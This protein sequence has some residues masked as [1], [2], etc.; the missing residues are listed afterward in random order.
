MSKRIRRP[1]INKTLVLMVD[2]MKIAVDAGH[3]YNTSGKRT[4]PVPTDIDFNKDGK[5]D[6]KKGDSIREHVAAVGV[7]YLLVQ[8]LKRCGFTT[9]MTGFNDDN[10]KDDP[11]T[12]LTERQV[13]I[14]N[15]KCDY[16]VSIHYNAYGDGTSFNSAE[17][18]EIYI[19][20]A[21]SGKSES[22]AKSVLK[23]L[24]QGTKQ[25]NRGI[26]KQALAMC[27][28]KNLGT[29]ASILCELCFMTNEREALQMMGSSA[30][31]KEAAQEICKGICEYTKVKYVSEIY[32]PTKTIKRTS[33]ATDIKWLQEKLNAVLAGESFI[34]LTVDGNYG[35][36]T[37]IAVLIYWEK[38]GW[39]QTGKDTGFSAGS[40]T[41][42]ALSQG[43]KS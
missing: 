33:S 35:N 41:I 6:V 15:A 22:L 39:N 40:N 29:K 25:T 20:N 8:E 30:Y 19:H 12:P 28:C 37:R 5:A 24:V 14:R 26:N 2:S 10:P 9:V 23:Y 16:S 13:T 43:R 32:T 7:A 18:V 21:Y 31:W 17:G 11:D 4:P 1:F 34:P 38:L 27:N 3:G 36:K 42:T